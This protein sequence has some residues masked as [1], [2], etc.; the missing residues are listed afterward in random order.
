MRLLFG[1]CLAVVLTARTAA[2]QADA[3][4]VCPGLR[5]EFAAADTVRT[6]A[7]GSALAS[8]FAIRANARGC[9]AVAADLYQ[10]A[11]ARAP[12]GASLC[13]PHAPANPRGPPPP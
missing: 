11:A 6:D 8:H 12:V 1:A 7:T 2:A 4:T 9:P 5:H 13:L 3:A 10:L